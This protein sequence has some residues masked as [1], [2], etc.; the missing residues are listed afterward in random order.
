MDTSTTAWMRNL[1]DLAVRGT[2][3]LDGFDDA[4][5]EA[6]PDWALPQRLLVGKVRPQM[7][8]RAFCWFICGEV[9]LDYLPGNVAATPREALR[10]FAMK[11]QLDA[12]R[13]GDA[14]SAAEL[15]DNAEAIY[16]LADDERAWKA[17][18]P[19]E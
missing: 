15:I 7:D 3:E 12:E 13:A 8:P 1:V 18:Q 17:Q 5:V 6:R 11:W 14:E 9:P 2:S 10:H 4:L 16:A 19:V